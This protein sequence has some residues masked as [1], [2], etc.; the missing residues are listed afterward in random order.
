MPGSISPNATQHRDRYREGLE[1]FLVEART[2]ATFRHPAIVRVAREAGW[3]LQLAAAPQAIPSSAYPQKACRPA[4]SQ[5]DCSKLM[6]TFDLQLPHWQQAV[7]QI[8]DT[9]DNLK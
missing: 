6:Q 4:N 9:L 5:L 3:P 2:L 1:S 8:F 7:K